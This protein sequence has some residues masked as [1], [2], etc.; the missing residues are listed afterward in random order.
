MEVKEMALPSINKFA[1]DYV[2]GRNGIEEFFHYDAKGVNVY[3]ERYRDVS[4]RPFDRDGLADS[5]EVYM[6]KYGVSSSAKRNLE[7]L[8]EHDSV[9]VI[10]GQQAG[11]LTGPLYTIHKLISVIKLAEEQER[12]LGVPVIP[13][14]WIAGEDHD[15]A[16]VNHVYLEKEGEYIKVAFEDN[17]SWD[18]KKMISD[19]E[20]NG[21]KAVR[22]IETVFSSLEETEHTKL[23]YDKLLSYSSKSV[24]MS[25]FFSFIITDLF[26]AYGVLLYDSG[27]KR[28]RKLQSGHLQEMI[29]KHRII[30]QAVR[31]QQAD[32]LKKGYQAAIQMDGR[33]ANLFLYDGEERILLEFDSES[34]KF[35]GKNNTISLSSEE[36]LDIAASTPGKLSNNVVTRPL[37]QEKLFPVLAFISG[38]GE[39]AYWAELKLVFE[40]FGMKMPILVPRMNITIVEPKVAKCME[41]TDTDLF[42]VLV[43]GAGAAK[44]RYLFTADDGSHT[45]L[46]EKTKRQFI[47]NHRL[48]T[49]AA[50]QIDQGL[51][52]IMRKNADMVLSQLAF[53]EE[54]IQKSFEG[55]HAKELLKFDRI[56]QALRPLGGPQERTVNVF[57]FLNKYGPEFIDGLM[58]LPFET[59]SLHKIVVL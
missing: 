59:N 12:E 16:E 52:G 31:T 6:S 30:N 13:V 29:G 43:K 42:E 54:R 25:D 24:S 28:F 8:K 4:E 5:I 17:S 50:L 44:E 11:L 49:E 32:I 2:K 33:N 9:V 34:G 20:F 1:S 35:A 3:K 53:I 19:V 48:L 46:Y 10:G 22:F 38:P 7:R 37:M 39:I 23:L 55:N 40:E 51:D 27:D 36:L 56:D 21:S 57:Y 14:F 26:R 18:N 58:D 41:E 15:L 47:E 45:L